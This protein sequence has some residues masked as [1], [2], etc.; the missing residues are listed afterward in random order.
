MNKFILSRNANKDEQHKFI[1]DLRIKLSPY[2]K[3]IF[4]KNLYL[5]MIKSTNKN[6]LFSILKT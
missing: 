4:L 6:N 2:Y 1:D 5:K 3:S